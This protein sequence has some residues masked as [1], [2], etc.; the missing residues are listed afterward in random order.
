M[1]KMLCFSRAHGIARSLVCISV[2]LSTRAVCVLR[3]D[4]GVS[5]KGEGGTK[6]CVVISSGRCASDENGRCSVE[7]TLS[8]L[9][10]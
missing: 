2:A 1:V 7:M 3:P 9:A 10:R 6:A 5:V 8:W 4:L